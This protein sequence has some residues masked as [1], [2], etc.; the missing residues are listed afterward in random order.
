MIGALVLIVPLPVRIKVG[1]IVRI[2]FKAHLKIRLLI[3]ILKRI[4][5]VLLCP[6]IMPVNIA[7]ETLMH[8]V[9]VK[10]GAYPAIHIHNFSQIQLYSPVP[11]KVRGFFLILIV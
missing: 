1:V 3:F 5:T 2:L 10:N 11:L 9:F 8:E 6:L 4:P 7:W